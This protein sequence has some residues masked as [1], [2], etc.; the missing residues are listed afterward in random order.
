MHAQPGSRL[1]IALITA[2]LAVAACAGGPSATTIP[3][4]PAPATAAASPAGPQTV[5]MGSFH[6]VDATATGTAALKHLT[7]GSFVVVFEDF[8]ID[9]A[10]H[11]NVVLVPLANVTA[12]GQVDKGTFLD[13]GA[14]K[15]T[16][17]M[18]DYPL[19]SAADAMGYHTVVLWD[20]AMEHALAA[21]P[22]Q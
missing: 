12:T 2:A 17:G 20:T 1:S 8:S 3:V 18:Q 11:T 10:A 13:L 5:G 21:A 9:S 16:S 19:P 4:T 15:G 22:L 6:G 14:L 7:D